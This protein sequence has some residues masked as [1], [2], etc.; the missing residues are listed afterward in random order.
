M[1]TMGVSVGDVGFL[2][3]ELHN[4]R[5]LEALRCVMLLVPYEMIILPLL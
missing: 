3:Y 1:Q 4:N 5:L 2:Q